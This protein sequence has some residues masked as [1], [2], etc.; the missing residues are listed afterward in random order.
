MRR[1]LIVLS[2]ACLSLFSMHAV[3]Q[4]FPNKTIR[5]INPFPGGLQTVLRD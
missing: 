4:E 3:A 2:L 5:I 1:N